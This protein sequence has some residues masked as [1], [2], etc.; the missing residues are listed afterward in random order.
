VTDEDPLTMEDFQEVMSKRAAKER[1]KQLNEPVV[2]ELPA[3]VSVSGKSK[4]GK[5]GEEKNQR[6]INLPPRLAAKQKDSSRSQSPPSTD[7]V[8][9]DVVAPAAMSQNDSK[10]RGMQPKYQ[11]QHDSRDDTAT[12]RVFI[13]SRV[14]ERSVPIEIPALTLRLIS[15]LNLFSRRY[16]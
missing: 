12:R 7:A 6:T 2:V 1:T 14:F 3:A 4:A 11:Q 16:I 8:V 13:Y 5:K 10:S 9:E 15:E